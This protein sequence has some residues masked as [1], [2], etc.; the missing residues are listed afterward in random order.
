MAVAYRLSHG[1]N[2]GDKIFSL[3]LERPEVGADTPKAHLDFISNED[4]PGLA[5]VPADAGAEMTVR[6]S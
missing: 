1:D 3:K 6:Y 5:D 4:A 2:V